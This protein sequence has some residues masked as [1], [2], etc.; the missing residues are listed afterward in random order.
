M[1]PSSGKKVE[2]YKN[3]ELVESVPGLGYAKCT[4]RPW[5]G[6]PSHIALYMEVFQEFI[7]SSPG[8][9]S[10]FLFDSLV[11]LERFDGPLFLW[12]V[13]LLGKRSKDIKKR[14]HM[15]SKHS[16]HSDPQT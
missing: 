6:S 8:W 2:Y 15:R 5:D 7:K 14:L 1:L 9:W 11:Y 16:A 13:T 12:S 10:Q 4:C 3:R